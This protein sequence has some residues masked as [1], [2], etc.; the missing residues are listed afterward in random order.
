MS[1][2]GMK[3]FLPF[4]MLLMTGAVVAPANA[5]IVHRLST[6]TALTVDAAASAATRIGSTYSVSGNNMAVAENETFGGLTAISAGVTAGG[7]TT[8]NATNAAPQIQGTYEIENA[9]DAFSFTES[10]TLGDAVNTIGSGT[11][12]SNYVHSGS[13]TVDG[14]TVPAQEDYGVIENL[15]AFGQTTTTAGGYTGGL[16][17]TINSAG[18]IELTAGGAGTTAT[19]QFV[20]EVTIR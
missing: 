4:A 14:V 17:G 13:T 19:G 18:Q 2:K 6:S 11:D 20:S 5:D 16:A 15:P 1:L 8:Y 10:Y 12:V 3:R 7:E 9:G